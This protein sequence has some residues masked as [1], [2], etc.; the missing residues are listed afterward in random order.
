MGY[1]VL[2]FVITEKASFKFKP[3]SF[4][5]IHDFS[6][7][8]FKSVEIVVFVFV[9]FFMPVLQNCLLRLFRLKIA[10]GD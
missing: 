6:C 5:V 8:F 4:S 3:K 7:M 9:C 1:F 10:I 2:E